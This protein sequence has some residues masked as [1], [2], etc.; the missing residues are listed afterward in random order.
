MMYFLET[1]LTEGASKR[2][3]SRLGFALFSLLS[4]MAA[5]IIQALNVALTPAEETAL[6]AINSD[7]RFL[8]SDNEV[9]DKI[10]ILVA[11]L[12]YKSLQSFG[13]IGDSN[14]GV[15]A[16]LSQDVLDPSAVGLTQ[17]E[18]ARARAI[19]TGLLSSWIT[20][21]KRVAEEVKIS[22][23]AKALRLPAMIPRATL[24]GLR[25]RYE[26]DHGRVPDALWPCAAMLEKFL[27]EVEEGAY[28]ATPLSE[29]ISMDNCGDEY[30]TI[31]EVGT[32]VKVRRAP[33][34]IPPPATTEAFR[35]RFRTMAMMYIVASYKHGSRL[36]LRSATM[37][38]F[39]DYVE[40]ILSDRV[41]AFSLDQDGLGVQ[42]AW[43][44][45]LNYDYQIRKLVVRKVLYDDTDF[46]T[47]LAQARQDLE[48]KE[49]YF[50]T[51]TALL[52]AAGKRPFAP[53]QVGDNPKGLGK[54]SK[55]QRKLAARA[56][57]GSPAPQAQ[58]GGGGKASS[59]SGGKGGK[60]GAKGKG[61]LKKTPD[62]RFI[63]SF[64]NLISGCTMS[65]EA[66]K[67]VHVCNLCYATD[68]CALQCTAA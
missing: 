49:R 41:A 54:L 48:C 52:T 39:Q 4:F 56:L 32:N 53:I 67:F 19:V 68:H 34:A 10:Q 24:L 1:V 28:S 59:S 17:V 60:A 43:S 6:Q 12:G 37:D 2:P 61:K 47:A 11:G 8:W 20:A 50:I 31:Q 3:I 29:V 42:A 23:D 25:K 45:V 44:T 62:G 57:S 18:T 33:K 55:K 51:P 22:A 5:A 58:K 15:R 26:T 30:S 46:A 27:D 7:L 63:C 14:A 9:P 38:V 64:F 16:L 21:S 13:V 40:Y 36:W 35:A 65:E 66:C